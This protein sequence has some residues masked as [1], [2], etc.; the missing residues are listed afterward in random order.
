MTAARSVPSGGGAGA[1]SSVGVGAAV[2]VGAGDD[3]AAEGAGLAQDM[4]TASA[5]ASVSAEIA[6]AR[7]GAAFPSRERR[8]SAT[9]RTMEA[10]DSEIPRSNRPLI[11][12]HTHIDQFAPAD[13]DPLLARAEA[14]NVG[15]IIAAGVTLESCRRV[16]DLA[17]ERPRIRAGVGLHPADL[18]G[19]L[20]DAAL[21]ELRRL[22]TRPG[23]VEWSEIGLDYTPTSPAYDLQQDAFRKQI[24]LAREFGLPLVTHSR[25][26][27]EDTLRI[28]R[29]EGAGEVGGAWH[30]FQGGLPLAERVM[31]LGFRISLA[32]PLL[33]L[34]ELQEA[35]AQIPLDRIVIETDSY[36]QPFKKNPVRRTEPWHL[37]QVAAKLAE[38]KGV[39][40]ETVAEAT[41][42]NYLR[43]LGGRV[44][45]GEIG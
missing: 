20:D 42:A 18:D 21:D 26:A 3:G 22:A 8:L 40:I 28:L 39:D 2:G 15:L 17:E 34:P 30:Y 7:R 35:A 37:P 36:P 6:R 11:D 5:N 29:E 45:A 13:L 1:G 32:K 24:R 19:W 4:A 44:S 14:A 10:V 33:R 12:G 31:E 27:D 25:E 41:T 43:M 38:L 9:I 23:I 16:C